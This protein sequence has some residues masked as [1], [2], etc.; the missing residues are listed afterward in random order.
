MNI[1]ILTH[2]YYNLCFKSKKN[3]NLRLIFS[4]KCTLNINVPSSNVTE[5]NNKI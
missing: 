2:A 5:N 4:L 3:L 1:T